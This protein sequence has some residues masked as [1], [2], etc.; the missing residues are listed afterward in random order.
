VKRYDCIVIG[1]GMA[2]L[3]YAVRAADAGLRVLVVEQ[4]YLPGG[5]FT[6]FT[7]NRFLFNVA[8]EW[9]TDCRPG[10]RFAQLLEKLGVAG[11][12]QFKRVPVFKTV[13]SEELSHPVRIF[14][15]ENE[16][17]N[18]LI[19]TFASETDNITRFMGDVVSPSGQPSTDFMYRAARPLEQFLRGYFRDPLLIQ[20]LFSLIGSPEAVG[21]LLVGLLKLVCSDQIYVPDFCDHRL[22]ALLLAGRIRQLGSTIRYRTGV[23]EVLRGASRVSG[24]RTESGEE[25]LAPVVVAAIGSS[26]LYDKLL[27]KE[28]MKRA[29]TH[30]R[31]SRGPGMSAFCV[32]LG[33]N[34]ALENMEERMAIL[35]SSRFWGTGS[36]NIQNL[37]LRLEYQNPHGNGDPRA[38]AVLSAWVP[39]T[40]TE[41]DHWGQIRP[42]AAAEFDQLSYEQ[43]KESAA[44]VVLERIGVV[45]PEVAPKIEVVKTASPYTFMR[46]TRNEEGSI[47]GAS[48]STIQYLKSS[49]NETQLSG[50]YHIG[51]STVQSGVSTVMLGASDAFD[52]N[53]AGIY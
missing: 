13:F 3:T 42:R 29:V 30:Q 38:R 7:H 23:S 19:R 33:L 51:H 21:L 49:P 27:H 20:T 43:A 10:D 11:R 36:P 37:P 47:S 4:H 6:A 16:L 9:T 39:S 31:L 5:L 45:F 24:I 26:E 48:L 28:P 15:S 35:S 44:R 1:A 46:Y 8:M 41:Y 40:V 17:K 12:C 32:F 52:R 50:L 53:D 2:G 14:C 22:L 18:E 34:E 25:I